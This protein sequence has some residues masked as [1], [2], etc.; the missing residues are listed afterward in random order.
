MRIRDWSSD[1]CSSDLHGIVAPYGLFETA[2]SQVSIAPSNDA[3]YHKLLDALDLAHLRGHADF[4]TNADRMTHRHAIK[5]LI[6]A[7]TKEQTSEYWIQQIG[8]KTCREKRCQ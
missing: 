4:A 2:D 8:R 7:R 3:V 6:E 1:V 5:S